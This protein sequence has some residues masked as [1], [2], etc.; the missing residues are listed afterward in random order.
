MK[1]TSNKYHKHAMFIKSI[2]DIMLENILYIV[3]HTLYELDII[4]I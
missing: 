2:K 1:T 4:Q 3:I